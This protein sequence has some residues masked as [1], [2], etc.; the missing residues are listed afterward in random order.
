MYDSWK[1]DLECAQFLIWTERDEGWRKAL[2]EGS[3]NYH[4]VESLDISVAV[5]TSLFQTKISRFKTRL[6]CELSDVSFRVDP[7]KLKAL[8]ALGSLLTTHTAEQHTSN[9]SVATYSPTVQLETHLAIGQMKILLRTE[10][11]AQH[12]DTS[13]ILQDLVRVRLSGI[14]MSYLKVKGDER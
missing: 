3:S 5:Q 1:I 13:P 4:I 12:H 7:F 11:Q 10:R 9:S 6:Q 2:E 14:A 8:K